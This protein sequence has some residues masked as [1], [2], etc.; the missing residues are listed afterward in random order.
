MVTVHARGPHH[1]KKEPG[2]AEAVGEGPV[3]ARVIPDDEERLLVPCDEDQVSV[4]TITLA[5]PD[6]P[7]TWHDVTRMIEGLSP[8]DPG[9]LGAEHLPGVVGHQDVHSRGET[10][11]FAVTLRNINYLKMTCGPCHP[12][13]RHFPP[14]PCLETEN[15]PPIRPGPWS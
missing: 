6:T 11:P 12:P 3:I 14:C 9:L 4:A 2:G 13:C 15:P 5:T 7:D 8:L 1:V 10:P